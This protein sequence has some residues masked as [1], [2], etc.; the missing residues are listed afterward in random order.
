[1]FILD[2]ILI[3]ML[4]IFAWLGHRDGFIITLCRMIGAVAGFVVAL[5]LSPLVGSWI[6]PFIP[7]MIG[8]AQF[9]AFLFIFFIVERALG[10]ILHWIGRILKLITGLPIV[11]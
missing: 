3:V 8:I 9:V 10:F 5:R 4:A 1:M 6:D 7:G 2:I 11:S